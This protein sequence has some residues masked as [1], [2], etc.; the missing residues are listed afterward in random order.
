MHDL[1][2]ELL[3]EAGGETVMEKSEPSKVGQPKTHVKPY[4][5]PKT[6]S[7]KP[8]V[9]SPSE[10]ILKGTVRIVAFILALVTFDYFNHM[11]FQTLGIASN[12]GIILYAL[13]TY[14]VFYFTLGVRILG[15]RRK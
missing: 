7:T 6:Q 1:Q 8:I 11:I 15:L 13:V 2:A 14:L 10:S 9:K 5:A 12:V 4:T 3:K